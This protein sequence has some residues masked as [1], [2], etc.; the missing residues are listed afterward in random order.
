[1]DYIVHGVAKSWTWLINFH[2]HFNMSHIFSTFQRC[3][4]LLHLY[5]VIVHG[6][7][8]FKWSVNQYWL[9]SFGIVFTWAHDG[10]L[11][12]DQKSFIV[13]TSYVRHHGSLVAQTVKT[14]SA[15]LETWVWSL[16]WEYPPEKGMAAHSSILAWRIP[17]T[18]KLGG[19][20]ST[21]S[22]RVGHHWATKHMFIAHSTC[23]TS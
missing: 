4:Q 12:R 22:P 15:V 16:G 14:P 2:F 17:W 18:E 19:L 6:A 21:G 10:F 3:A 7:E 1:M 23:Q 8:K 5:E 20:Q 11:T 13:A 9:L